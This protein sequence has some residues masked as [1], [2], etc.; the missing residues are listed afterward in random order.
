MSLALPNSSSSLE[1]E[2]ANAKNEDIVM[3]SSRGDSGNNRENVYPADCGDVIS[4]SS[5]TNYGKLTESTETNARYFFQGENVSVPAEPSYLES[6]K[7][8]SG[9]SVATALAAGL[10]AL[11]IS[12]RRLG[13]E[14]KDI[15]RT[16]T[17][18]TVFDRMTQTEND[19]YVRPWKVFK[20]TRL[21]KEQG[22][23]WLRAQ[24]GNNGD[25]CF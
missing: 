7:H 25:F 9:S 19:K 13:N 10:A 11:I 20:D 8:A 1:A 2:V 16:R 4:I 22:M 15:K 23:S 6:Q 17:V 12:C 3:I 18:T 5:L 24:F 14:E 21:G